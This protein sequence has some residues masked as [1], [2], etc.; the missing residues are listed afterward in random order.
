MSLRD[1]ADERELKHRR[2]SLLETTTVH[3]RSPLSVKMAADSDWK[4]P[5]PSQALPELWILRLGSSLLTPKLWTFKC[6]PVLSSAR[7]PPGEVGKGLLQVCDESGR[8]WPLPENRSR[9]LITFGHDF[10]FLC[11]RGKASQETE[12]ILNP[13]LIGKFFR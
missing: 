8:S 7:E 5:E 3:G 6:H 1:A 9:H 12:K 2:R 13:S 11:R 10:P 4:G